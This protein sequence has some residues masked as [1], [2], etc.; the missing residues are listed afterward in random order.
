MKKITFILFIMPIIGLGQSWS[1]YYIDAN[2]NHNV[3][4]N[5]NKNVNVSGTV[6]K[7]V[8][9]TNRQTITTID[10]GQLA[11]ANAQK[12]KNRLENL[13]YSDARAQRVALEIAANP[14][15]AFD[16]GRKSIS[17]TKTYKKSGEGFKYTGFKKFSI[18]YTIPHSAIFTQAGAG[19]FEN[20]S[21]EGI[22]VAFMINAPRY[23]NK[24]YPIWTEND[25][26]KYEKLDEEEKKKFAK[27][28]PNWFANEPELDAKMKQMKVGEINAG[29]EDSIFVHKKDV[30]RATVWGTKG[31]VGTLIW[32]DEYQY[33]I[34]DNYSSITPKDNGIANFV[35]VRYYGDK[36]EITFEQL[37]GR[38][39]YLKRLVEKVIATAFVFDT[40]YQK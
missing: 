25:S 27:K 31:Y 34:T 5:I 4:A 8:K 40:K 20:V 37:E 19:R 23:N 11:L 16:Y 28:N 38:R 6:N 15:K 13:Q 39:Y 30:N 12:E 14:L 10:Y 21:D 7:N 18:S 24:G 17:E 1:N 32:E 35:K 26:Y 2:V 36:D 9:V 22:T 3:N 33:C 29:S